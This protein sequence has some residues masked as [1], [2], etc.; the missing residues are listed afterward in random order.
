MKFYLQILTNVKL[1]NHVIIFVTI[2]LG[3]MNVFVRII[4][5]FNQMD[6]RAEAMV[7]YQKKIIV[8]LNKKKNIHRFI[9]DTNENTALE[10]DDL[11]NEIKELTTTT[12]RTIQPGMI[13][14]SY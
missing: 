10:L 8:Y 14:Y 12:K 6:K 1:R 9:S 11:N 4:L 5:F 3:V 13:N 7:K 2:F